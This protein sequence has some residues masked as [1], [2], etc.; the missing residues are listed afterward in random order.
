[1]SNVV[2]S[3][4]VPLRVAE[5]IEQLAKEQDRSKSK[6]AGRILEQQLTTAPEPQVQFARGRGQKKGTEGK[7]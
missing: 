5:R 3:A 4:Y 7:Q 2:I 6:V 1:M